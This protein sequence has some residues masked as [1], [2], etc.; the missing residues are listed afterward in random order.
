MS[1]GSQFLDAGLMS[2]LK[3]ISNNLYD[4]FIRFIQSLIQSAIP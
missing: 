2:E 1:V 3:L 4:G